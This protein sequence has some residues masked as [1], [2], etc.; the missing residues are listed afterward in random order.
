MKTAEAVL[1]GHPDKICDQISDAIVD[2]ILRQDPLARVAVDTVA[3]HGIVTITGEV[4]TKAY[5]DMAAIAKRVYRD[6]GYEDHIG[7]QVNV[8]EQSQEIAEGVNT[9]GAGDQGIMVG[10]A[11]NS[12]PLMI[13]SELF[14]ARTIL[15][16]LPAKGCGPDGK[17][18]V[19][20]KDGAIDSIVLSVQT[21][22][23]NPWLSKYVMGLYA[24]T[25]NVFFNPAG[26][27][28]VGGIAA[29]T[30][31]TG[32]KL[33]A[34]NYGPQV[35]IGGGAFSGKDPSKVDRS[36]AYMARKI[37]VDVLLAGEF[38][39]VVVKLAYSIGVAEPVMAWMECC[40]FGFWY[41]HEVPKHYDLT[42][43]GIISLLDLRKPQ[44]ERLAREGHF[45]TGNLWDKP[46]PF[47]ADAP[48]LPV[49]KNAGFG[50]RLRYCGN[51]KK[52]MT[53]LGSQCV[54]C[55]TNNIILS[56]LK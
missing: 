11:C 35:P 45:G 44:Y 7:V 1:P 30:G 12:N 39:E 27:F 17:S 24:K 6:I 26:T 23:I 55:G 13:P 4:T 9:G 41:E 18:Q 54:E 32:R 21:E 20:L 16:D 29:D 8:V 15:Q 48:E 28:V 46:T 52:N 34:D 10:Y 31:L 47:P 5:C 51:C 33:A 53:H 14:L 3:G 43:E 42:P 36:G 25:D 40:K 38:D 22:T 37:A 56:K 19:T 2:D 49:G 50:Y